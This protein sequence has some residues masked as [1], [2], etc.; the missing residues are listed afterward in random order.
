MARRRWVDYREVKK[1][2]PIERVLEHYGLLPSLT[3][4]GDELVGPCSIHQ[5]HDRRQFNINPRM[6]A[7]RCFGH[8]YS[9]GNVLDLVALLEGVTIRDAA[10]HL[11]DWFDLEGTA[12]TARP[13]RSRAG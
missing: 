3:R 6:G 4:V 1:A 2:V 10:L 5:G 11:V 9:D 7:F 8:C 13:K 12:A